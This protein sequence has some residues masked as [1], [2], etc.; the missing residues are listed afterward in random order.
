M[1]ELVFWT[2]G[3]RRVT[4]FSNGAEALK[5]AITKFSHEC[6]VEKIVRGDRVIYSHNQLYDFYRAK[7][8]RE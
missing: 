1:Y 5:A 4:E 3:T 7:W 8:Y 2:Y 6:Y